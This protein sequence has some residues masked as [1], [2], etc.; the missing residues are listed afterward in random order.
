MA[1][2]Q[3]KSAS[4]KV[5]GLL[6][7]FSPPLFCGLLCRRQHTFV[8]FFR[9]SFSS[10]QRFQDFYSSFSSQ[11]WH[12]ATFLVRSAVGQHQLGLSQPQLGRG[13]HAGARVVTRAA[14]G[15]RATA[16]SCNGSQ[17]KSAFP[18]KQ[19]AVRGK[20]RCALCGLWP[21]YA[22][23]PSTVGT[24]EQLRTLCMWTYLAT[25]HQHRTCHATRRPRL[26]KLPA[27]CCQHCHHE[28]PSRRRQ[29]AHSRVC[30]L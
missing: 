17:R 4:P 6:G 8:L 2:G 14:C 24:A 7:G 16:G 20:V 15:F 10:T 23:R 1:C 26:S 25:D 11:N 19:A 13:E 29:H 27:R 21:K 22:K 28:L 3:K 18:L 30:L 12:P 5:R 9:S